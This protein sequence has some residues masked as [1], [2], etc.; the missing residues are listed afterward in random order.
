MRVCLVSMG[1][2]APIQVSLASFKKAQRQADIKPHLAYGLIG[3][4]PNAVVAPIY[5]KAMP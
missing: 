1:A 4:R 2:I 5:P 3:L